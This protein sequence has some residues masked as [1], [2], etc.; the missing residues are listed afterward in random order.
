LAADS[1]ALR[2]KCGTIGSTGFRIKIMS[3][4][5]LNIPLADYEGHMRSDEVQQLDALS[6]LFAAALERCQPT[7]VAVLGVGGGNGLDRI[8][9]RV[10]KRV[11]GLDLNPRY[12]DE[13]RKRHGGTCNLSLHCVDLAE[14]RVELEPVHL[15][16]AALVFEHAGIDRCLE[17]AISLVDSGGTLCAVLQLPSQADRE[18]GPS[19][20]SSILT[21]QGNFA[22]V[23]PIGLQSTLAQVGFR[24]VHEVLRPVSA[25]KRLWMGV[26]ER[27]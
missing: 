7:S 12:L 20:F 23:D 25:G 8:D 24:M 4:P 11:V 22:L 18:I 19:N 3:N 1:S 2:D 9:S 16:H 17:T 21:L 5:W 10:T 13:T 27:Y 26:F 6:E 15:V 14:E